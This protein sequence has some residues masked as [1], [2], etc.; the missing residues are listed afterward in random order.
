LLKIACNDRELAKFSMKKEVTVSSVSLNAQYSQRH[1]IIENKRLPDMKPKI[2]QKKHLGDLRCTI[3]VSTS[4]STSGTLPA[5]NC[6][7]RFLRTN[8]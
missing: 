8:I 2:K 5:N 7:L 1:T 6:K 3:M 4:C